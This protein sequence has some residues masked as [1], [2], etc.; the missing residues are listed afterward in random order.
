MRPNQFI[1]VFALP[2]LLVVFFMACKR[3]P[4][5]IVLPD[6]DL[7][8]EADSVCNEGLRAFSEN[9][10]MEA[11]R[12]FSKIIIDFPEDAEAYALRSRVLFACGM[13]NEAVDDYYRAM[14]LDSSYTIVYDGKMQTSKISGK[15]LNMDKVLVVGFD[16]INWILT[17]AAKKYNDFKPKDAIEDYN[18]V[19]QLMPDSVDGYFYRAN[20]YIVL[21]QYQ[22]A[23][24]DY[25]W[26]IKL[27]PTNADAYYSRA[28]ANYQLWQRYDAL[29]DLKIAENL[30]FGPALGYFPILKAFEMGCNNSDK[31]FRFMDLF[32][33]GIVTTFD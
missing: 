31:L 9:D 27:E 17:R 30:G 18:R 5:G 32:K 15:K 10:E 19:I 22:A 6:A 13:V 8:A 11:Y 21:K 24:R 23:E 12:S 25:S 28:C 20:C 3:E 1:N 33:E 4:E 2:I 26:V 14:R 16:V 7:D 29:S